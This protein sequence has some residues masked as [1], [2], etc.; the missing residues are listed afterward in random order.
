[1]PQNPGFRSERAHAS[2]AQ[3]APAA[4]PGQRPAPP[5]GP[6]RVW[7]PGSLSLS[8]A[9]GALSRGSSVAGLCRGAQSR[10]S[11]A[12]Y[13]CFSLCQFFCNPFG[14]FLIDS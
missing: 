8:A 5:L 3:S 2:H 12:T 7:L 4:A 13:L 6:A 9:G 10:G 11:V 14:L 1:M